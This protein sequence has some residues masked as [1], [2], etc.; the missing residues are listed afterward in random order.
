MKLPGLFRKFENNCCMQRI[1]ET[2][3]MSRYVD[4]IP[5]CRLFGA[6]SIRPPTDVFQK[7]ISWTMGPLNDTSRG[8][9][10]VCK[11][12]RI[13][14]HWPGQGL[15]VQGTD[16]P[17]TFVRRHFGLLQIVIASFVLYEQAEPHAKNIRSWS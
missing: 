3:E 13:C 7:E 17:R 8:V 10:T 11:R 6:T 16:R 1:T 15:I 14:T 4:T 9:S 5:F 2:S 12:P